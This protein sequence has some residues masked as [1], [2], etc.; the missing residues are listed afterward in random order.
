MIIAMSGQYDP[1]LLPRISGRFQVAQINEVLQSERVNNV[2]ILV[3]RGKLIVDSALL[4]RL[5]SLRLIVKAGTGLDTIDVEAARKRNIAVTATGGAAHSVADLT[6]ALLFSC[7]RHVVRFHRAVRQGEWHLK[8]RVVADTIASRRIGVVG[9][10][11]IGR[12][13]AGMVAALGARVFVWDHTIGRSDKSNAAKDLGAVACAYLRDLITVS[14][15][16]SLHLPLR[17]ET[18]GLLGQAE[19]NLMRPGTILINTARA[20]IV[21]HDALLAALREGPLAAA[22]L[23][24]HYAEGQ[25]ADDPILQLPNVVL[26]PH[27]GAQ[28]R[29]AHQAIADRIVE[30]IDRFSA[31]LERARP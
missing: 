5:S 15:V 18:R 6:L 23:D 9:F 8:D 24:V 17:P 27:V 10:G 29:Q 21:D 2:G 11:R 1:D 7:L 20:A 25:A 3:T 12:L 22:G 31:A 16:I 4:D 14:D 30:E 26:T 19:F 13:A 28:T